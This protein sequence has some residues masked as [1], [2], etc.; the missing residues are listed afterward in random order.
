MLY[1]PNDHTKLAID[2]SQSGAV[3]AIAQQIA[4]RHAGTDATAVA[5]LLQKRIRDPNSV[6][7]SDLAAAISGA[8]VLSPGSTATPPSGQDPVDLLTR[9]VTLHDHGVIDDEEFG[10]QKARI[11]D[12]RQPES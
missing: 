8:K 7:S 2:H 10:A 4:G 6:S 12:E 9:L 3:D 5:A 1:D 11:L